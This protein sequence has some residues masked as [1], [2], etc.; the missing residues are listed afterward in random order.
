M[1]VHT[2]RNSLSIIFVNEA[3]FPWGTKKKKKNNK[4]SLNDTT[5][6]VVYDNTIM[7]VL[8]TFKCTDYD[9]YDVGVGIEFSSVQYTVVD[10]FATETE[11]E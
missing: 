6:T 3:P 5:T 4:K 9:H 8:H 7:H 10:F 1:G 11:T 2:P